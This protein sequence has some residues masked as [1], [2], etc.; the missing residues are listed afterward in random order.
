MLQ[1]LDIAHIPFQLCS[2]S[3][4]FLMIPLKKHYREQENFEIFINHLI[5]LIFFCENDLHLQISNKTNKVSIYV[6]LFNPEVAHIS[7]K[8]GLLE[9]CDYIG[10]IDGG[11]AHGRWIILESLK[12][13]S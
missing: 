10:P 9:I 11:W 8:F 5:C 7:V 6:F 1:I 12:A 2:L 3:F 4:L 13:F